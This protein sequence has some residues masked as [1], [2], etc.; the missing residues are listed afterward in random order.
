VRDAV[1]KLREA[2]HVVS[3]LILSAGYGL[4]NENDRIAPY[5]L[6]FSRKRKAWVEERGRRLNLRERLIKQAKGWDQVILILGR[7]YFA[8]IGLPLPVESLP[9]TIAYVAPSM[10]ARV[11]KGTEVVVVGENEQRKIRVYSISAKEKRFQLDM[12]ARLGIKGDQYE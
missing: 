2:G 11:G 10:A 7:E 12:F 9:L 4:L 1:E 5:D 6:T 3:H 8:A